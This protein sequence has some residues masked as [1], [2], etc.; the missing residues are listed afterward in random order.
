MGKGVARSF[1]ARYPAMFSEYRK[2]CDADR[3]HIGALHLWKGPDHW[4]LNFPTKTTWR[5]PSKL[6]YIERGLATFVMNYENMGIVSASFPPLGCGNGN[7]DW[8]DVRPIMESYLTNISIP[9]YVHSLHVGAEFVPEH[10]ELSVAPTTFESFLGDI[11]ASVYQNRGIYYTMDTNNPFN[12]NFDEDT[13]LVT[14]GG[15]QREKIPREDLENF[16]VVL[17]DGVLSVE[18]F[19]DEMARRYKSYVFPILKSLPY[20][21]SARIS[22]SG[23]PSSTRAQA[24]FFSRPRGGT[25]DARASE[26]IQTCLS[27]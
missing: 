5:L 20:V 10:N 11:R 26:S 4:V 22:H 24:L 17:R 18:R 2:L 16:W 13:I 14:R 21:R 3:L 27:L 15:R 12:V 23:E 6:E 19:P 8:N 7:L 9:V 1:R 25:V